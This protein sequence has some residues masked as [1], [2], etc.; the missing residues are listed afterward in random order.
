MVLVC[1][2]LKASVNALT[3]G[4]LL[5]G[6]REQDGVGGGVGGWVRAAEGGGGAVEERWRGREEV[7]SYRRH[8]RSCRGLLEE[9]YRGLEEL[10]MALEEP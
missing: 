3:D 7:K 9:L 5:G 6:V 10:H 4:W 8:W 2:F 1:Y